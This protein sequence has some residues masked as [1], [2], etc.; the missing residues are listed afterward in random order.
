MEP[1]FP[2]QKNTKKTNTM[3]DAEVLTETKY[4]VFS[5][6]KGKQ[7]LE[8]KTEICILNNQCDFTNYSFCN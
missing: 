2:A 5:L 1:H 8:N 3:E 7:S 4:C 6:C